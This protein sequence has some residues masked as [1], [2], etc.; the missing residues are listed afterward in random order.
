MGR[1]LSDL[2]QSMNAENVVDLFATPGAAPA[3]GVLQDILFTAQD[4]QHSRARAN[5]NFHRVTS[6]AWGRLRGLDA[7]TG[8]FN[9][10]GAQSVVGRRETCDVVVSHASISGY[11]CRIR[12]GAP[13]NTT[14]EDLRCDA[15]S[16][17]RL[18][19]LTHST[20]ATAHG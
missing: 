18:V 13:E 14:I 7:K 4:L 20:A 6:E 11:H 2:R 9:L 5:A 17:D 15:P 10:F 19:L 16:A 1:T 12:K 8:T 3:D